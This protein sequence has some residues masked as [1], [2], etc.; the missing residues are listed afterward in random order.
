MVIKENFMFKAFFVAAALVAVAGFVQN[1]NA[2]V[3]FSDNFDTTLDNAAGSPSVGANGLNYTNF[4]LWTVTA[5]SVDVI[6]EIPNTSFDFFPHHGNYVDLDGSTGHVGQMTSNQSFAAG[7]Y[8]LSFDLGGN[9]RGAPDK[10]TKIILGDFSET[11]TLA[12]SAGLNQY[13]STFTTTGG[14][15]IFSE[16]GISDNQ[17]NILDNVSVTGVPE[18]STWAMMIIGFGGLRLQMRRRDRTVALSA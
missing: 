6:G 7:T 17:G 16:L 9:A 18:P 13:T 11:I 12:S 3:V 5:G 2:G 1:A 15:L 4:A 8:T 14:Q 10:A